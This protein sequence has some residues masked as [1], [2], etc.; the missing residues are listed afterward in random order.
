[1]NEELV[2]EVRHVSGGYRSGGRRN[3]RRGGYRNGGRKHDDEKM[4]PVRLPEEGSA[5]YAEKPEQAGAS[6]E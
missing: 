3:D 2:L 5:F 1:M 6:E 4:E